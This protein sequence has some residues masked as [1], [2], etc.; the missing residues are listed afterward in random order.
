MEMPDQHLD[1]VRDALHARAMKEAGCFVFNKS[2]ER[3]QEIGSPILP[4]LEHVV[5]EEVMPTSLLDPKAQHETFPGISGLM[6]VYLQ[7][8]KKEGLLERAARFVSSLRGAVLIEAVRY[9]SIEWDRVIPEPF[10][11]TLETAAKT[12]SPEEREIAL[13][14]LDWHRNKPQREKES[15]D[16]REEMGI[17]SLPSVP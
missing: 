6:V 15:A 2:A 1:L 5:R 10:M 4:A 8:V 14:A 12:G 11:K 9:I 7:I 16:F 3:V 13:W 17:N